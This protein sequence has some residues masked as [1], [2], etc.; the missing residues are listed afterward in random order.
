MT[1]HNFVMTL[2]NP[3][4]LASST[5]TPT[6]SILIGFFYLALLVS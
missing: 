6:L 5:L 3:S 2:V 1:R 4:G